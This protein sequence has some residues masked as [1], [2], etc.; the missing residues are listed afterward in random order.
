MPE[1]HGR[2]SVYTDVEETGTRVSHSGFLAAPVGTFEC[3]ALREI[4]ANAL[5]PAVSTRC[6]GRG[7]ECHLSADSHVSTQSTE[8][9]SCVTDGFGL[10]ESARLTVSLSS[11]QH[12]SFG[13]CVCVCFVFPLHALCLGAGGGQPFGLE[14][15]PERWSCSLAC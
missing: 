15:P 4:K 3:K 13:C 1:S 11:V 5:V 7:L 8:T 14:T 9:A 12:L 6:R 10:L 2:S